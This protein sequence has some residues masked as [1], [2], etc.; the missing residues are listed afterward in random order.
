[1]ALLGRTVWGEG[2]IK[3]VAFLPQRVNRHQVPS[4]RLEWR[5]FVVAGAEN[6]APGKKGKGEEHPDTKERK[7]RKES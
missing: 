1:M 5:A 7:Q 4:G 3:S 6:G 2:E